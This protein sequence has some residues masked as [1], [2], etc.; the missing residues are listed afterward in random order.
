ML[1]LPH[2]ENFL[3]REIWGY[4]GVPPGELLLATRGQFVRDLLQG[5]ATDDHSAVVDRDNLRH[6]SH[7]LLFRGKWWNLFYRI[8]SET[9]VVDAIQS[10][11]NRSAN[12]SL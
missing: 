12:S 2:S 11:H 1:T 8:N 10:I 6:A 3:F 4:L 5:V 7:L 9:N